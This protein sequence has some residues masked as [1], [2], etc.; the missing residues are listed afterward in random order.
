MRYGVGKLIG[1]ICRHDRQP[2]FAEWHSTIAAR[3]NARLRDHRMSMVDAGIGALL[4]SII[5]F[6]TLSISFF[7]P[8][9]NDFTRVNITLPPGT[10]LKQTEGVDRQRCRDGHEGP[11]H[12]RVFEHINVGT[13]SGEHRP[14]EG[15]QGHEHRVRARPFAGAAAFPDARVSFQGQNGGGP[16]GGFARHHA[17][18]SAAT[19][20]RS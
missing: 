5:L 20:P 7:P 16:D 8:Q 2:G 19:I 6:G 4:V 13:G 12:R 10:T 1:F 3:W 11:E 15:S 17:V 14:Q 18:S 9:N